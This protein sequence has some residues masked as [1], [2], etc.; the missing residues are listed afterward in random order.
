MAFVFSFAL[1][2]LGRHRRRT[3]ITAAALAFGLATY[4]MVDSMLVGIN[5]ESERNLVWYQYGS[6]RVATV[7]AAA[8]PDKISLKYPLEEA[9]Q[10]VALVES[11]GATAAPRLVFEAELASSGND[12]PVSRLVRALGVDPE[13]D[14]KVFPRKEMEL[15]GRWMKP[16]E[17]SVVLG[18][19][20]ADDLGVKV[21]QALTLTTR[22]REGSFQVLD[23]EVVGLVTAPNPIVNRYGVFLPLDTV[24]LQLGMEGLVTQVSVGLLPG[25]DAPKR[26]AELQSALVTAGHEVRV[27]PW[28]DLA[29]DY[30]ALTA[31]KSKGSSLI[32]FLVFIIAAVGVGN[33]LLLSFYERKTEIGMLRALGMPDRQLFWAF[34]IEAGGIGLIGS[35]FGLL[36]GGALVALLVL[37]GFD[38]T[39]MVRQMDIGYPIA[40][41]LYGAWTPATFVS[42]ALLGVVLSVLV[43]IG[44]TRRALRLPITESLRAE[45]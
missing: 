34:L 7:Q 4:L 40:G 29:K 37:Q 23:V 20:I 36:L 33:T 30:L 3:L 5:Q 15:E 2:N 16:G 38:F 13:L 18:H 27:L 12:Q 1:K 9:S 14:S 21:G 44:P 35:F 45:G 11:L 6:A 41:V 22:T 25:A 24:Q 8:D 26:A 42:A 39:F 10:V 32:L 43:A 31:A 28:Q 19:W 17:S